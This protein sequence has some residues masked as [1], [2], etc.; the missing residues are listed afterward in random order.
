M[1]VIF[2]IAT[3]GLTVLPT[4]FNSQFQ[5]PFIGGIFLGDEPV[6]FRQ[7]QTVHGIVGIPGVLQRGLN[8]FGGQIQVRQEIIMTAIGTV[9]RLQRRHP[10][11][12]ADQC[13]IKV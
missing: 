3:T 1:R 8:F 2:R 5:I 4:E 10:Q 7:G 9:V 13:Q 6:D 12:F 11:K